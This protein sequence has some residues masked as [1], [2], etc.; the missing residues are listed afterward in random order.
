MSIQLGPHLRSGRIRWAVGL[1]VASLAATLA[2][3]V[4]RPSAGASTAAVSV[5]SHSSV[6]AAMKRAA[7]YYRPN[8]RYPSGARNGWSWSTYFQ[9]LLAL[10]STAGDQK[11]LIDARSWGQ[12]THWTLTT[13]EADPDSAKAARPYYALRQLDPHVPLSTVDDRIAHDLTDQPASAYWWADALFMGLPN[14]PLWAARTGDAAYLTKLDDVY[15]WTRDQANAH[16]P[17]AAP[18]GLYDADEH[19]WLRDCSFIDKPEPN[20]QKMFWSRGNGW[21]MAAMAQVLANLPATQQAHAAPYRTML[22]SMAARIKDL[23]GADGFWR[24]SLLD[25]GAYPQPE[26]SGTALFTYA[27]AY[28]IDAG[29]LDRATYLPVVVRAWNGL[30]KKALQGS[31]FVSDCQP[32]AGAPGRSYVGTAPR[33]RPTATSPGTLIA[34]SPPFCVGAFLLAGSE[35]ARLSPSLSTGRHVTATAAQ[36]GN[37]PTRAVDGTVT[38]Y[39]TAKGFPQ[40][41]VVDLGAARAIGNTM[42]VPYLDRPYRYR[43]DTSADARHWRLVA[44]RT[45]NTVG[46]S[47]FVTLPAPVSARYI[48]LTVT[49]QAGHG[50]GWAA[51][52]EF[53][54]YGP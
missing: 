32:G 15:A 21:V 28:G 7:D 5:P 13:A 27:L 43:L 19:L 53:G 50:T 4:A 52:Q 31:G 41:L 1:V 10:Y 39:W 42:V 12:Q 14:W 3:T 33:A 40:S 46:G 6:V 51:I 38:T 24:S 25:P 18:G 22:Q 49:G 37:G 17:G 16:C 45:G 36:A 11:Y 29:L 20:G 8:V 35:V 44:S 9:G 23:Q 30:A 2:V 47:N 48:R 54:V 26:T 34:D